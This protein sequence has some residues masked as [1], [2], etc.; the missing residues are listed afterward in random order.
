[1]IILECNSID[2]QVKRMWNLGNDVDV[3]VTVNDNTYSI[4]SSGSI[5]NRRSF[6]IFAVC[7]ISRG[8]HEFPY[9][10]MKRRYTYTQNG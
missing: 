7:G 2:K 1:M 9:L 10:F 8:I 5:V 3:I 6:G 4:H